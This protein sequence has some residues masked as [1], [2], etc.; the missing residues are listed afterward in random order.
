MIFV[1]P[2]N[3]LWTI[4]EI[5]AEHRY[6]MEELNREILGS[7]YGIIADKDFIENNFELNKDGCY[8]N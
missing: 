5:Y 1:T 2:V 6:Y 3:T 4:T 7:G 8:E